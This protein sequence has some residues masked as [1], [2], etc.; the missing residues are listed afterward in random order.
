MEGITVLDPTNERSITESSKVE[1]L[2][3][4]KGKI[5]GFVDNGKRNSDVVL[6]MIAEELKER[7]RLKDIVFIRKPSSSHQIPYGDATRLKK[8][9]DAVV[10]GIGD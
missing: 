2:S 5:V 3:T 4:L 9:C 6:K 1:R 8:A 7:Y 10:T